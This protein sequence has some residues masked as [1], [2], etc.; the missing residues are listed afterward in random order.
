MVSDVTLILAASVHSPMCR[1]SSDRNI[2]AASG[3]SSR[4]TESPKGADAGAVDARRLHG[5]PE[6]QHL[7][8]DRSGRQLEGP[9]AGVR[10]R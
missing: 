7:Q 9:C 10:V 2:V 3:K 1:S 8:L 4:T 5:V 6:R